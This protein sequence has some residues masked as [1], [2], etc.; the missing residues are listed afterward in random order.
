MRTGEDITVFINGRPMRA[1]VLDVDFGH[2]TL[3]VELPRLEE[4]ED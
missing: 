2:V 3:N 4:A 1:A